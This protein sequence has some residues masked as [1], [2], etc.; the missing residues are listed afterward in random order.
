VKLTTG[1]GLTLDSAGKID[2]AGL[3]LTVH[4]G[5]AIIRK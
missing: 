3:A 4:D 1:T 5:E 2:F